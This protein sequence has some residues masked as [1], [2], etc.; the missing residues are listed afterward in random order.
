MSAELHGNAEL[1]LTEKTV[2]YVSVGSNQYL[3]SK[4]KTETCRKGQKGEYCKRHQAGSVNLQ[5]LKNMR[6]LDQH[7]ARTQEKLSP[8]EKGFIWLYSILTKMP[9]E[10]AE[11]HYASSTAMYTFLGAKHPDETEVTGLQKTLLKLINSQQDNSKLAKLRS[12]VKN[13]TLG[14]GF[15]VAGFN[16]M[17]DLVRESLVKLRVG[18]AGLG[19]AGTLTLTGCAGATPTPNSNT[20]QTAE[21]K[22][23]SSFN[24]TNGQTADTTSATG[25][26]II[27]L[28]KT[29]DS[30]GDYTRSSF[31]A[32]D[33]SIISNKGVPEADLKSAFDFYSNFVS[34]EVMDSIALDNPAA[35]DTWKNDVAPKYIS[36]QYI[37]D[38]LNA[39]NDGSSADIIMTN[40]SNK[41]SI[42]QYVP[43]LIRDGGARAFNKEITDV[44]AQTVAGGIYIEAT[45]GELFMMDDASAMNFYDITTGSNNGKLI[46]A[47]SDG[48]PQAMKIIGQVGITMIKEGNGWKIAGFSNTFRL[49]QTETQDSSILSLRK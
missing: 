33:V 35:W 20:S 4:G 45:V 1:G 5:V 22:E 18:I 29:S 31:K 23:D 3:T 36:S 17:R 39:G 40:R 8:F 7:I 42:E 27:S 48:I 6:T 43:T 14:Q 10:Q 41:G 15:T 37:N 44:K 24:G 30:L 13:M 38:I 9:I 19:L 12:M 26:S 28:G 34:T 46:P 49:D 11:E 47:Y 21:P 25:L 32:P 2:R 16:A